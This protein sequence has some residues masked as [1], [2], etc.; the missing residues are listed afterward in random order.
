[1]SSAINQVCVIGAG[2]MGSGIAAQI[3]NAGI[4]VSLLDIVPEGA[5]NRNIIGEKAIQSLLKARPAPL[6]HKRFAKNIRIGNL[7]DNLDDISAADWIIEVVTERID[8][9]LALYKK[10][11]SVRKK[12]S[13]VSSNTST[14]PLHQLT[15]EMPKA[16]CE[17]FL[18]THFFNPPRYMRLIEV[19]HGPQTR[20]DISTT[21]ETFCDIKLGKTLVKCH[22]TP[23]FIANRIGIYWLQT[24]L[25]EAIRLGLTVEEADAIAGR[26][27]G[28]P[29]TGVFG[30]MDLVGI[31]LM[32]YVVGSMLEYLPASDAYHQQEEIP[33]LITTMIAGGYTGRKGKGGFY[34]LN[35]SAGK[36]I[37]ESIDLKTGDYAITKQAQLLSLNPAI[38]KDL[39][40]LLCFDDKG[41]HFAWAVLSKVLSY[42]A[43]LVGQVSDSIYAIDQAMKLG[44]NWKY[45]PF[46]LIDKLGVAWF[47]EKLEQD[48]LDIPP[49]LTAAK[50]K[51]LFLST[52][53]KDQYLCLS[54]EYK[55]IPQ[56]EGI[57]LLS[58]IKKYQ[59]P[60]F[61]N[62]SASLWDISDGVVCLEFHSKMN[63]LDPAI[64]SAIDKAINIVE[65]DYKALVL[66][67]EGSNY[68]VGAN[69]GL[70]LFAANIAA[71]QQIEQ[72]VELGQQTLKRMKYAPFPV[73]G[74][75]FGMA[76]GGG[77]ESLLHC[78]A[79]QAH[80]ETYIGLVEVGVG[81]IPAW[82]GIKEMTSRWLSNP[83]WAKGPMPAISKVFE[84]I[85]TATVSTSAAEAKDY[86]FLKP[87]DGISMNRDR[88]LF[89]AKQKALSLVEAYSP[90]DLP[91]FRLAGETARSAFNL[92]V[93]SFVK[94]GKATPYDGV[95]A[96]QLGMVLS[97][98]QTDMQQTLSEND[99][100]GLELK[101][102]MNL[103]KNNKS[104]ARVE[105]MLET[106]K[107]LRN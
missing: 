41:G 57:L 78:D 2:V 53:Q 66:Y 74:A 92:A 95:I 10:I 22:D 48:N 96:D 50:S 103:L 23:G 11:N 101:G 61:K 49:I 60:L 5:S 13:I 12:G 26:P 69:I 21:L 35:K 20:P 16:F 85:S 98:D 106:G 43:S 89:D 70:I 68:S 52:G 31:D 90:P 33:E 6:M 1:M 76:L 30:L 65:K 25:Q 71:W 45:G 17:D 84:T 67:N 8:I 99:L 56:A 88:L 104:L 3:A 29:K 7:E 37:K 63:A 64:F 107:P 59:Q 86:L 18:I 80:A 72:Q 47:I 82:G 97:G 102:F 46:E 105:H 87:D 32:P 40:K 77:C 34:R 75:P 19:I 91:E 62:T 14:L 28:I 24:G 27:M 51:G 93:D 38:S 42:S 100:L 83:N 9:K 81:L 79:I 44:Y 39:Q 94:S 15:K 54:G 55:N 36:K 4:A 73:V 58:S